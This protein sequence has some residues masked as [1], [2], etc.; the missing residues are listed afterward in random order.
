MP[1]DIVPFL[2]DHHAP[3]A[4][5]LAARHRADQQRVAG[6]PQ[7]YGDESVALQ[8]IQR[9][10]TIPDAD[11]WTALD[12]GEVA[13]Y[14]IGKRLVFDDK[15]IEALFL[16]TKAVTIPFTGY[17]ARAEDPEPVYRALYAAAAERWVGAGFLSHSI[18][19]TYDPAG[20]EPWFSLGFGRRFGH[21]IRPL[22]GIG[23]QTEWPLPPG[24]AIRRAGPE[25]R[26]AMF[27]IF[28]AGV[29]FHTE[30][31]IFLPALPDNPLESH[32]AKI[33]AWLTNPQVGI[34]VAESAGEPV[35]M[36]Q[37][38]P[39]EGLVEDGIRPE[40]SAYLFEGHVNPGAR[41]KGIGSALVERGLAWAR[42][43]GYSVC[44]VDWYT[45]NPLSSR[46]WPRRGFV[47]FAGQLARRIDPRVPHAT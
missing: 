29:Q 46:F 6:L 16:D 12:G 25:D 4:A 11:G 30:S 34:W 44:L 10:C 32:R 15:S 19:T 8:A 43:A 18:R 17:A 7:A 24:F 23:E 45:A 31:P 14:L 40:G 33:G 1:F 22:D 27:A 39:A 37:I 21:G 13:G 41:G 9:L 28:A 2:E 42:E 36:V 5:L 20:Y 38:H 47:P 3:V 35:G 26:D